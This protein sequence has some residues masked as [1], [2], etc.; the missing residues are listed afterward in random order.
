MKVAEHHRKLIYSVLFALF[1][2]ILLGITIARAEPCPVGHRCAVFAWDANVEEDLAGYR[3]YWWDTANSLDNQ[4]PADVQGYKISRDDT[5]ALSLNGTIYTG[6][7]GSRIT[8]LPPTC[9]DNAACDA[10]ITNVV[11]YINGTQANTEADYPYDLL[12]GTGSDA[13]DVLPPNQ[14]HTIRAVVNLV[15]GGT[16]ELTAQC[17]WAVQQ[18]EGT[19][20]ETERQVLQG[21]QN[22]TWVAVAYDNDGNES[23][24]SNS[25]CTDCGRQ[26]R[27]MRITEE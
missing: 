21:T 20:T 5:S 1:S 24:F 7:G 25:V 11:F 2:F 22:R 6:H 14:V 23:E 18:W 13:D 17:M 8:L 4:Y 27:N 10:I 9:R 12:T 19:A 3:V 15:A 26:V 16:V